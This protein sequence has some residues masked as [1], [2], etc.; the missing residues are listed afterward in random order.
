MCLQL[1]AQRQQGL[2]GVSND[3]F[4]RLKSMKFFNRYPFSSENGICEL[5]VGNNQVGVEKKLQKVLNSKSLSLV[6]G[7]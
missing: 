3:E 4:E 1:Q 5:V 2:A 7:F 6:I